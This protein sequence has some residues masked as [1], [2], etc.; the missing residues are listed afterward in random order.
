MHIN[1]MKRN[2]IYSGLLVTL[3]A[4]VITGIVKLVHIYVLMHLGQSHGARQ[5]L[6]YSIHICGHLTAMLV[7]RE[8]TIWLTTLVFL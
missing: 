8:K 3:G 4:K 2:A 5:Y 7:L 1:Q 6:I